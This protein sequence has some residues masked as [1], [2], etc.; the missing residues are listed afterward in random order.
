MPRHPSRLLSSF[1]R[2]SRLL[3]PSHLALSR[4]PSRIVSSYPIVRLAAPPRSL[5]HRASPVYLVL[6][7][8]PVTSLVSPRLLALARCPSSRLV[9]S[10]SSCLAL[11]RI[12]SPSQLESPASSS[13]EPPRSVS[14]SASPQSIASPRRPAP[15][16]SLGFGSLTRRPRSADVLPSPSL[17]VALPLDVNLTSSSSLSRHVSS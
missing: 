14:S 16:P 13:V 10:P 5:V 2:P 3:A 12:P 4:R 1:Y 7:P 17:L 8:R 15:L 6:P 11:N 9:V